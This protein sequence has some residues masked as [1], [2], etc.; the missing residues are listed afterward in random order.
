MID[1]T[2]RLDGGLHKLIEAAE[3]LSELN[4][5]LQVQ[6]T[7]VDEQTLVFLLTLFFLF[8]HLCK[9]IEIDLHEFAEHDWPEQREGRSITGPRYTK[10]TRTSGIVWP[11]PSEK[12][13]TFFILY[14]QHLNFLCNIN[15]MKNS[16][17]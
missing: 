6:K 7:H 17:C 13:Y 2:K 11:D 3:H 4:E 9:L 8:S 14:L 12:R 16:G 5:K 10:R 1:Q 15:F